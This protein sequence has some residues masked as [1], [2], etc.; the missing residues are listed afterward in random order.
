MDSTTSSAVKIW[1]MFG[2]AC[3]SFKRGGAFRVW[4]FAKHLDGAGGGVIDRKVL[5]AGMQALRVKSHNVRRWIDDALQA[6]FMKEHTYRK[7]GQRVY[8]LAGLAGCVESV[9][10]PKSVTC[11]RIG[12]PAYIPLEKL[13]KAGWKKYL[14]AGYLVTLKERPASQKVK[15]DLTGMSPRTQRN[16]QRGV[17]T[18][19]LNFA[20]TDF[21]RD[22]L[23]G[24]NECSNYH[25]FVSP[26][27]AVMQRLPDIR[28]VAPDVAAIGIPCEER[29]GVR[30]RS[31]K[32][33]SQ[34]N[35]SF[36]MQ[37]TPRKM[38]RQFNENDKA[39]RGA[40]K[41]IA[42]QSAKYDVAPWNLPAQLFQKT[43]ERCNAQFWRTVQV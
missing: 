8:I 37:R 6:G 35:R 29:H 18:Q 1:P 33:Q 17:S 4:T 40:L 41:H 16:L 10:R 23:T 43:G 14:W 21:T 3:L 2:L 26:T 34:L 42:K 25:Y 24:L 12:I 27:G 30:G 5:R 36:Q 11:P 19:V 38:I 39:T 7:S 22:H 15:H 28:S 31:R 32:V 13:F 9:I 20:E